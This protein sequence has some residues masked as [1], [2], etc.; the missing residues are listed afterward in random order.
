VKHYFKRIHSPV[1][2]GKRFTTGPPRLHYILVYL[3]NGFG[4]SEC[5]LVPTDCSHPKTAHS[6]LPEV[7]RSS[8]VFLQR[9][10]TCIDGLHASLSSQQIALP[11]G[12]RSS[13]QPPLASSQISHGA[14][15][16]AVQVRLIG[17]VS[18]QVGVWPSPTEFGKAIKQAIWEQVALRYQ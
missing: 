7:E 6:P 4:M 18:N 11:Q 3:P 14:R 15:T 1:L 8:I 16:P 9:Y 12:Y 2:M 13:C 10:T 17:L 5:S